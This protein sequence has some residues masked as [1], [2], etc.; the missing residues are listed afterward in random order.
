[1]GGDERLPGHP[2]EGWQLP[3][4]LF[5]CAINAGI[6]VRQENL[7]GIQ[8]DDQLQPG[9]RNDRQRVSGLAQRDYDAL[10]D[11]WNMH[12][13]LCSRARRKAR[14]RRG[15]LSDQTSEQGQECK[16]ETVHRAGQIGPD[17]SLVQSRMITMDGGLR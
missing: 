6:K 17:D 11:S 4:E 7:L 3:P 8:R 15:R 13:N 9:L 14:V 1:M 5:A 10:T 16:D 12:R 2:H